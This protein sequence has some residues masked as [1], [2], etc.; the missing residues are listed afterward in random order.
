MGIP[1]SAAG[2]TAEA[3]LKGRATHATHRTAD[4]AAGVRTA[5]GQAA[6][7]A[8]DRTPAPVRRATAVAAVTV[9]AHPRRLALAAAAAVAALLALRGRRGGE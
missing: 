6:R 4:A 5:V 3:D 9:R 8:R 7:T 1:D 2:L